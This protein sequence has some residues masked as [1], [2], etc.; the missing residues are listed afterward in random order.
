MLQGAS[1][2]AGQVGDGLRGHQVHIRQ[3]LH[4]DL[5][6]D[7]CL[8]AHERGPEAVVYAIPEGDWCFSLRLRI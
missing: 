6:R 3:T 5:E 4:E 7:A 2:Q 8:Q 1:E